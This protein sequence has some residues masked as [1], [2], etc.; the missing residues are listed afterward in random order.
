MGCTCLPGSG[1]ERETALDRLGSN[2]ERLVV[3]D[4]A[5][6]QVVGTF[7]PGAK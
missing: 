2:D 6:G 7:V 1:K 4:P 5:S 3:V